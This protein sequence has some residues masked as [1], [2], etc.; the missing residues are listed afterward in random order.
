LRSDFKWLN[1]ISYFLNVSSS[2][3]RTPLFRQPFQRG[4]KLRSFLKLPKEIF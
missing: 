2:F 4:A 1:S 3:S